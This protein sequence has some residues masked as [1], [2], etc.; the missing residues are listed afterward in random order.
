MPRKPSKPKLPKYVVVQG[1]IWNVRRF[2]PSTQRDARGRIIYIQIKQRC[3]PETEDRARQISDAIEREYLSIVRNSDSPLTVGEYL[4]Q[5][6]VAKKGKV[7]RRTYEIDDGLFDRYVKKAYIAKTSLAELKP[8]AVQNF[9]S[10]L[11][12][13]GVS[14]SMIRKLHSFLTSAFNQGVKW[15]ALPKNPTVGVMLPKAVKNE[16]VWFSPDE[17]RDLMGKFLDDAKCLVLAVA[18]E[19]G[20]RPGEYLALT[21]KDVNWNTPSLSVRQA[22]AINFKGGGFEI[23]ETKTRGSRRTIKISDMLAE[24]LK[25]HRENQKARIIELQK[26]AEL[27]PLLD[28]IKAKGV[29]YQKRRRHKR[30]AIETLKRFNKYDLIFPASNGVP[31]SRLNLN[32]RIFKPVIES[33]GLD[34]SKYSLY[35]LRHT[36]ATLSLAAGANMKAVA[37]KLGHSDVNML[38]DTY[39]HVI[40]AM[41]DEVTDKLNSVLYEKPRKSNVVRMK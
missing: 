27:V 26:A 18:L 40:P 1:G 19:T 34:A 2:F 10:S 3:V 15:E 37:E 8:I 5:F 29:N 21:W 9:Y 24:R 38:L 13:S 22:V 11:E 12:E 25:E 33:I 28:H 4:K 30:T 16:A 7:A 20:M 31:M 23:K 39:A 17:A 35:A 6:L 41:R 32:R 14:G 36:C